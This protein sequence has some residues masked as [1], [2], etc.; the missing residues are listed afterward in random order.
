MKDVQKDLDYT[1]EKRTTLQNSQMKLMN[2]L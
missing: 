1:L 2:T